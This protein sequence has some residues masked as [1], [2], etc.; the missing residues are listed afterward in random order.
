M[1]LLYLT[2]IIVIVCYKYLKKCN[3]FK[4]FI[5]KY[6]VIKKINYGIS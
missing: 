3:S 1:L 2:L 5:H 4:A 6:I